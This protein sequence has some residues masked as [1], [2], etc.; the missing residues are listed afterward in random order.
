MQKKSFLE[1]FAGAGKLTPN[2]KKLARLFEQDYQALAFDNL[3]TVSGRAKVSKS[4]VSRFVTKLG[5]SNFHSF[6]RELREEV[7]E[8]LD[9][10]LRR[11]ERH[12]AQAGDGRQSFVAVHFA[13]VAANLRDTASRLREEDFARA[14]DLLCDVR[15]PL[16]LIGC[17]AAEHMAGYFSLLLRNLRGNV[18]LLDGNICTLAHRM[19][20]ITADA[21]LFAMSFAQYPALTSNV[22]EYFRAKGSDVILLTDRHTCPILSRATL[23]LVVH[24]DV[25]GRFE[26]CCTAIAVMEALLNGMSARFP[27]NG[28]ERYAALRDVSQFLHIF[29]RE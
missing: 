28:S 2:E 18:T 6:I 11:Q 9:T 27:K 1:R 25:T 19:G 4:A 14:L 8:S 17:A 16:F 10:P 21:V 24:A 15:R 20:V 22:V 5:Y 3:E 29:A 23:P 12:R 7:A 13:E 26:T